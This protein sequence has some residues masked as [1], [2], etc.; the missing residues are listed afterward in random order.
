MK[1]SILLFTIVLL[2]TVATQ[3]QEFD[4]SFKETY[5]IST[6]AKLD[7]SS[8]DGDL[9]IIPSDG[10]KI[11]VYYIVRKG[12]KLLKINREQLEKD[13][14]V[15]VS[16]DKNTLKISARQKDEHRSLNW[17]FSIGVHF[18]VYVPKDISCSLR[19]SDGSISLS[20]LNGD[21]SC[22][23]SDG[24]I[25]VSTIAGNVYGRTSD[26]DVTIQ[27]VKGTVDAGTSDGNIGLSSIAGDVD[28][29]T[30]DGNIRLDRIKGNI[31]VKTSDGYID[32]NEISGS[33][34]A[35]TSDGNI[36]GNVAEL[37]SELTL[38]TSDGNINVT[39]PSQLGLDL[40]IKGESLDVPFKN[41]SG[42]FDEK[43]VRGKS[44]GGGIPVVLTTSGG[45]VTL[46]Y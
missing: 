44:N 4:Y 35:S 12:G 8:F 30:S 6:P 32:F 7:L 37:R 16:H 43:H 14:I 1:K 23:T 40:D 36:K 13:V 21:Q 3:A 24:S 45:N 19:S 33:F 17:E 34:R 31:S 10:N 25:N 41:F 42:K 5:D 9:D 46:N 27:Q 39:I 38:R 15:E 11:Q 20:K 28:A 29:S 26:G 2:T 18:K 22:K